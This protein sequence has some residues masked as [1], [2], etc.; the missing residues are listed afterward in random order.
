MSEH[1]LNSHIPL[2][3]EACRQLLSFL[4]HGLTTS[5][6]LRTG[7]LR[8]GVGG[9]QVTGVGTTSALVS[10][11]NRD[12]DGILIHNLGQ[13]QPRQV[14]ASVALGVVAHKDLRVLQNIATERVAGRQTTKLGQHLIR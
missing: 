13:A 7:S 10:A 1:R 5:P 3:L 8:H 2:V 11:R 9:N 4:G 14:P 12:R 6:H